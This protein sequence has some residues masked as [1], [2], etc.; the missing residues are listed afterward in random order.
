MRSFFSM[1]SAEVAMNVWMRNWFAGFSA[2]AA[3][4]M[5]LSFARASE[6]TVLSLTSEAIVWIASKSPFELAAKPASITSTF[7][8]SS[9]FAIRIFS[10]FVID[11]PGDCSPS[12]K[13][14]SKMISLSAMSASSGEILDFEKRWGKL[15]RNSGVRA[16]AGV[17]NHERA[18]GRRERISAVG[19]LVAIARVAAHQLEETRRGTGKKFIRKL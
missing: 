6:Q 14:V 1:C 3:R 7:I 4:W 16:T 15:K 2:S 11:A 13:V 8:R 9:C 12:R 18:D 19:A 5:S 17:E 10:S